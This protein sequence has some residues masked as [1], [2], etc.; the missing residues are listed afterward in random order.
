MHEY[1][2][3]TTSSRP[4]ASG[5]ACRL[6]IVPSGRY[7]SRYRPRQDRLC[8]H[9]YRRGMPQPVHATMRMSHAAEAV[10]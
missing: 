3:L 7:H 9:S 8:A 5:V 10:S 4:L 1:D 2:V 6:A